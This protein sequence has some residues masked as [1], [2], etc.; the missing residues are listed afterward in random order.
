MTTLL[1][2][3]GEDAPGY[4]V[5]VDDFDFLDRQHRD[6]GPAR[7]QA[8]FAG[9]NDLHADVFAEVQVGITRGQVIDVFAGLGR[10]QLVFGRSDRAADVADDAFVGGDALDVGI[11]HDF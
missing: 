5:G 9:G 6:I 11:I 7:G 4:G 3:A 1:S 2:W 10:I 8:F